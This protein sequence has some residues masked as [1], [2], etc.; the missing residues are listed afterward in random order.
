MRVSAERA[1]YSLKLFLFFYPILFNYLWTFCITII[2]LVFLGSYFFLFKLLFLQNIG[3]FSRLL[4][5]NLWFLFN[6]LFGYSAAHERTPG[7]MDEVVVGENRFAAMLALD[8]W[9]LAILLWFL[10]CAVGSALALHIYI[11][12]IIVID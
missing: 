11:L 5:L 9:L 4:R 12:I 3:I 8:E 2:I 10:F 1:G 6:L 7:L